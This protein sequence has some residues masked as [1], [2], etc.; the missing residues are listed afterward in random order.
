M[1]SLKKLKRIVTMMAVFI[2]FALLPLVAQA[3]GTPEQAKE[4]AEKAAEYVR[5]HGTEMATVEFNKA[6]SE[7]IVDDLYVFVV[8]DT[9]TF[10]AH[11]KKPA[12]VGK[13]MIGLKDVDGTPLVKLFTEVESEE[14]VEY[15]WPHPGTKKVKPKKSYIINVDGYRVGVGAYYEE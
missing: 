8:D 12:L 11:P 4:M 13:N 2:G 3:D 6:E 9:G 14:W 7:F 15:K 10:L 5:E 1:F